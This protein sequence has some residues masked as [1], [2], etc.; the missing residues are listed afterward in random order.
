MT[1]CKILHLR[2]DQAIFGDLKSTYRQKYN[3]CGSMERKELLVALKYM[4]KSCMISTGFLDLINVYE[5]KM[6]ILLPSFK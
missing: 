1:A 3:N 4:L 6:F 5:R 2:T